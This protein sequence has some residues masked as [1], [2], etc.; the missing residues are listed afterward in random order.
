MGEQ[1]ENP[2]IREVGRD[3]GGQPIYSD[4]RLYVQFMAFGEVLDLHPLEEALAETSFEY[5]LYADLNDPRGAGLVLLHTDPAFFV[6][7]LRPFLVKDPFVDLAPKP[8]FTMFGRTY[9][10]G[11]EHDLEQVLVNRARQR[12]LD[13]QNDWAVW[14]PLRR[15]GAFAQL[16]Q[17][18]QMNI[19]SEHGA[20]G[21]AYGE[22]GFAQDVRLACH[23]LD[24]ADNDFV[25]GLL[26]KDLMPLS[27][28]VQRMR[29][30]VQTSQYIEHLGP[31]F[32][33]KIVAQAQMA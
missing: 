11:Y 30:T 22:A 15:S 33:G 14:Y 18:E 31:F 29:K 26:G 28:L 21:R 13:P 17:K 8:E 5:A 19:L 9:A 27:H 1:F 6:D 32:V 12:V 16:D 10:V 7:E 24:K 4:R 3:P 25:I 2:E 23:G 20:I